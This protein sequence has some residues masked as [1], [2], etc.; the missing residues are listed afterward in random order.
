MSG[1]EPEEKAS[2][3]FDVATMT[4]CFNQKGTEQMYEFI[5]KDL[6]RL[7]DLR[8]FLSVIS[9]YGTYLKQE[10]FDKMLKD[11]RCRAFD[12]TEE[13]KYTPRP[14]KGET[15]EREEASSQAL[16]KLVLAL[17]EINVY[18]DEKTLAL[19]EEE[20]GYNNNQSTNEH[21]CSP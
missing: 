9:S 14:L 12:V 15:E 1:D 19:I 7:Q 5:G 17:K 21:G 3:D 10:T 18:L 4:L 11:I 20:I 8:E 13:E 2:C 16:D 6:E